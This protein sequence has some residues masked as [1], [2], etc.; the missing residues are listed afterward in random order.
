MLYKV[1]IVTGGNSGVGKA[2]ASILFSKNAKV[3]IGARSES[4][5]A[6]TIAEIKKDH[7]ASKGDIIYLHLELANLED[8]RQSAR[9]F[10]SL[11]TKLH[12]LFNNAATQALSDVD[13]SAKTAQGHEQHLGINVFAPFLFTKLLS[14][15]LISTAKI[16]PNAVR[17]V[18]VSSMGLET[19]GEKSKGL[20]QDYVNYWPAISPLE[21]YGLSKAGN[22][23]HG[24][25]MARRFKADGVISMPVNP[26][27]L[28]SNLYREG[29]TV[30][31]AVLNTVALYPCV[32]GAYVE[33]FA[34]FSPEIT[35][36]KSGQWG[37]NTSV[38]VRK[39]Y[40]NTYEQWCHGEDFT[41]FERT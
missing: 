28:A 20:S 22:W 29:G 25:E 1:C 13:G 27:H 12:I 33:L 23:L 32:N 26:G 10:L 8:V 39:D 11:E 6:S 36:E 24:V 5:A 35:L 40:T 21:R 7:P 9:K 14:S 15:L 4:K 18:W 41:P 31:K 3:Y 30:F 34:A 2:L 19:I 16:E 17:V 38:V 37:K